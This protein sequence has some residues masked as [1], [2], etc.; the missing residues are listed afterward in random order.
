MGGFEDLGQA[1]SLDND[2]WFVGKLAA[3]SVAGNQIQS[4]SF[5][6]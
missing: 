6:R 2:F 4:N 3:I 5:I 1:L